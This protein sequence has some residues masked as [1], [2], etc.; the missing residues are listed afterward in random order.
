MP[1][2]TQP[3]FPLTPNV[4]WVVLT[5][6]N[7]AVD[8]T[9][10]VGTV[11]TAGADGARVDY[12]KLRARGTNVAS[13]LRVFLNNGSANTTA[14]NNSL[15][16]EYAL[17]ATTA[18]AAA[19]CGNDIVIPLNMTIPAGWKTNVTLGTAVAAGWQVTGF[20]GNY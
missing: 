14:A 17:P 1:A 18:S 2:N 9:G 7:T 19:E 8:G 20:G 10:T 6:A 13:V 4:A 15:V 16:A 11:F 3:I 5:T 12:L